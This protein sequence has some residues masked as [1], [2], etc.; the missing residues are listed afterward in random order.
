M[1]ENELEI[2][3][4]EVGSESFVAEHVGDELGLL[5]L[6]D[7][8]FLFHRIPSEKSVGDNLVL[9]A[10]PVSPVDR[11]IFHRRIPPWIVEDHVGSRGQIEPRTPG[12]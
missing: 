12:F 1:R 3:Q 7:A 5:V 10:D 8:N 2:V 11:L 6:Q 9:L 4:A